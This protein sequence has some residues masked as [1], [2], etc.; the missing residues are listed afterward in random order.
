MFVFFRG[1]YDQGVPITAEKFPAIFELWLYEAPNYVILIGWRAPKSIVGAAS[2]QVNPALPAEAVFLQG[3]SGDKIDLDSLPILTAGT[4]T[5]DSAP[6]A[7]A[8]PAGG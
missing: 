8:A 7:G 5:I 2:D 4:L 6:A 3:P 1:H